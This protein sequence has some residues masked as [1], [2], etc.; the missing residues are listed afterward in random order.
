MSVPLV[1]IQTICFDFNQIIE[2][3]FILIFFAFL[4]LFCSSLFSFVHLCSIL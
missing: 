4:L 1:Y 3:I 2:E